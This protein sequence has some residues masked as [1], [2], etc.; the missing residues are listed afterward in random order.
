MFQVVFTSTF[1][2][3]FKKLDK[4]VQRRILA[5]IKWLADHPEVFQS[6][7]YLPAELVGLKKYRIGDWR[8][9]FWADHQ[10]KIVTLYLVEHRRSIY[11]KIWDLK[12]V[13]NGQIVPIQFFAYAYRDQMPLS[14]VTVQTDTNNVGGVGQYQSI[15]DQQGKFLNTRGFISQTLSR[16]VREDEAKD[17]GLLRL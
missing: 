4:I 16:C 13:F 10:K 2:K 17:F 1:E 8:I 9:L 5:K 6:V 11:S 15:Y 14:S 3:S 7:K 12:E